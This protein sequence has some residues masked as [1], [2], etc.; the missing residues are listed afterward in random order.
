MRWPIRLLQWLQVEAYGKD[1]FLVVVAATALCWFWNAGILILMHFIGGGLSL[2]GQGNILV[3]RIYSPV[4]VFGAALFEEI[5]FRLP[6][7]IFVERNWSTDKVLTVAV[8]LSAVF[9][10]LHGGIMH[11]FLQGVSGFMFSLVFLKCGGWQRNYAKA[12]LASTATHFL[13]NVTVIWL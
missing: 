12:V 5:I 11:V 2:V 8:P 3:S 9:G 13:F 1:V 4:G 7:A 6:L 10:Y